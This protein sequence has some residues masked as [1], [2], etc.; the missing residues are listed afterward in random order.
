MVEDFDAKCLIIGCPTIYKTTVCPED[1]PVL[2]FL[3]PHLRYYRYLFIQ[4]TPSLRFSCLSSRSVVLTLT[5]PNHTAVTMV[6][7][8]LVALALAGTALADWNSTGGWSSPVMS[9]GEKTYTYP[10]SWESTTTLSSSSS[11]WSEVWTSSAYATKTSTSS[12]T[13]YTPT[14]T[15]VLATYTTTTCPVTY[16]SWYHSSSSVWTSTP[17][18]YTST[19]V[20]SSKSICPTSSP[21]YTW[22]TSSAAPSP[23][24]VVTTPTPTPTPTPAPAAPPAPVTTSAVCE[25][26]DGQPQAG[27]PTTTSAPAAPPA[28]VTTSAVCEYVDG[29][30]QAG[31]PTTTP[32]PVASYSPTASVSVA[33]FTGAATAKKPAAA[34]I[35]G[36]IAL[37]ALA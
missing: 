18:T 23:P 8:S 20:W 15:T 5:T 22:V 30:P 25:Y 14:T 35:G 28:P 2:F 12:W 17:V 21:V 19:Y 10:T 7:A 29:Q 33:P 31:C 1:L 37:I 3:A 34:L 11:T 24:P 6:S 4:R 32:A 16:S 13:V 36:V 26:V 27:C 9:W